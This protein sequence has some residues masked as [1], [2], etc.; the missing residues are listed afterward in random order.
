MTC[1]SNWPL[2]KSSPLISPSFLFSFTLF[3]IWE[4]KKG[5]K[6]KR[7]RTKP[8]TGWRADQP[9]TN[10][11]KI[12]SPPLQ[13]P[14][15]RPNLAPLLFSFFKKFDLRNQHGVFPL[16]PIPHVSSYS[17]SFPSPPPPPS[18]KSPTLFFCSSSL[19][20]HCCAALSD[21]TA[22]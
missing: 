3:P 18:I 19:E 15:R 9:C 7:K 17:P 1:T 21:F 5:S 8:P 13:P 16:S 2:F 6:Q 4:Y 22:L 12:D 10:R 20:L 11:L 14:S